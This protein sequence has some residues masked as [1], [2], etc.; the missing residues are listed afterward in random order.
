MSAARLCRTRSD[1]GFT[2]IEVLVA[3][4][5]LSFGLLG[6]AGLQ[7]FAMRGTQSSDSRSIALHLANDIID[8]IHGNRYSCLQATMQPLAGVSGFPGDC[9]DLLSSAASY[10]SFSASAPSVSC[11]GAGASCTPDVAA[12]NDLWTW[13]QAVRAQLPG[14][15]AVVCND[16]TPN[17]GQPSWA[18]SVAPGAATYACDGAAVA[19]PNCATCAAAAPILTVKIWWN[20]RQANSSGGSAQV[21]DAAYTYRRFYMSFQ[22]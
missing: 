11:F 10:R 8:R 1:S 19:P 21:A 7:T 9:Y 13:L 3:I 2:L 17:D 12:A 4:L 18:S 5:V 15:E 20:D 16:A 14:G 6:A 22:P